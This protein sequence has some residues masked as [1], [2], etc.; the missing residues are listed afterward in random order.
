MTQAIEAQ[1]YD[2]RAGLEKITQFSVVGV[3]QMITAGPDGASEQINDLWQHFFESQIG[4]V[5]EQR[6]DDIVY[7][8]YSDYQGDFSKPYRLTIGFKME[9]GGTA[10]KLSPGLLHHTQIKTADYAMM[11]AAGEQP[12]RSS[13]SALRG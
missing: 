6:K 11:A 1:R 2:V 9:D 8:V 7:A 12:R 13:N 5:L 3:S 10:Q 4:H